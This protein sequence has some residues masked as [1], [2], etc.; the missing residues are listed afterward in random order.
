M[1]SKANPG[2]FDCYASALPDEPMFILLAR[3]PMAPM[4]VQN[5]ANA[6]KQLI[7]AGD[8]PL[9]DLAVV[10]E[11]LTC[12]A[13]M[14][15]WRFN[16][17]GKWRLALDKGTAN[18]PGD[19]EFE[20][21]NL[22]QALGVLANVVGVFVSNT[23]SPAIEDPTARAQASLTVF[24]YQLLMA[25]KDKAKM[26]S[27]LDVVSAQLREVAQTDPARTASTDS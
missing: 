2:Q 21:V 24:L 11:A 13:E 12:A 16:N 23:G 22:G 3:D 26:A 8:K 17:D 6:R 1:A 25:S 19:L 15:A 27:L 10:D 9:D 7:S 14:R 20:P 5:W 18:D 4:I